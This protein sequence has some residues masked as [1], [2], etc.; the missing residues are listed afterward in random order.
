MQS[1]GDHTS[2]RQ[3]KDDTHAVVI[4]YLSNAIVAGQLKSWCI[5]QES[6][7]VL[8]LGTDFGRLVTS[9]RDS[10]FMAD[11][12]VAVEASETE[13]K[14]AKKFILDN[15]SRYS[16]CS[17]FPFAGSTLGLGLTYFS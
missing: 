4:M 7:K 16:E 14:E 1:D 17:T 15:P 6:T 2:F 10:V 12:I 11:Q 8:L 9:V 5:R 3:G 13:A